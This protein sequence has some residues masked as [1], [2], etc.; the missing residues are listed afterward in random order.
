MNRT[1]DREP[2]LARLVGRRP[3]R[4]ATDAAKVVVTD[5]QQLLRAE[6]DLAKAEVAEGVKSKAMGAGFFIGAAIIGWLAIQAFLV[7]LGFVFATFM[8][9]WA[10]SGLVLLLLII[11]IAVLGY[12]GMQKMKAELSLKQSAASREQSKEAATA[13]VDQAKASA[14]Q[15]VEE[16][17]TTLAETFADVKQR[18]TGGAS[19]NGSG[20]DPIGPGDAARTSSPAVEATTSSVGASRATAIPADPRSAAL[21]R[22]AAPVT[23]APAEDASTAVASTPEAPAAD[24]PTPTT[25]P[26]T[27]ITGVVPPPAA[28]PAPPAKKPPAG[29]QPSSETDPTEGPSS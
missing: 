21:G 23:D 1:T 22:P 12:F 7:W 16:A 4:G 3:N 27:P 17:K 6:I 20:P 18:L 5:L 11:A 26:A 25:D 10:A 24:E 19:R 28:L 9:A 14:K 15:G 13:A 2:P 8:P 29:P